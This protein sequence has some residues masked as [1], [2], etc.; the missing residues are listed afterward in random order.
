MHTFRSIAVALVAIV[1]TPAHANAGLYKEIKWCKGNWKAEL[2]CLVVE[3]VGGKLVEHLVE[4]KTEVWFG[5]WLEKHGL[6]QRP[7]DLTA[8]AYDLLYKRLPPLSAPT[9]FDAA[10]RMWNISVNQVHMRPAD[11][12]LENWGERCRAHPNDPFCSRYQ[13]VLKSFPTVEK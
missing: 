6:K 8:E 7:P 12:P 3:Q 11:P 9:D 10:M 2:T 5:F 13:D 4:K 1:L